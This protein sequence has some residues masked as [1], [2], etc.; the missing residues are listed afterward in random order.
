ME[1]ETQYLAA[2][3]TAVT[4]RIEGKG[5][6]LRTQEGALAVDFTKK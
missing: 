4:Y 3:E 5:M 1:Q 2:L 6:E